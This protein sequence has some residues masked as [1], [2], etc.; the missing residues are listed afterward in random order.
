MEPAKPVKREH[1][2]ELEAPIVLTT[3]ADTCGHTDGGD[4]VTDHKLLSE[5]YHTPLTRYPEGSD[6][7]TG[8][9]EPS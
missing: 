6:T 5:D 8:R 9:D 1:Q 3:T 7:L 4:T 2:Q